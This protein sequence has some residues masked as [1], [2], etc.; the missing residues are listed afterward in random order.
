MNPNSESRS[1][2]HGAASGGGVRRTVALSLVGLGLG[3]AFEVLFYGHP[4]GLSFF[5]FC[6]LCLGAAAL[7]AGLERLR[8]AASAWLA[9][10]LALLFAASTFQRQEPLTVFLGVG[11]A[12][13]YLAVVVRV[14]RFGRL[15]RFGWIDLAVAFFWVPLEA[16]IRPWGTVGD[17]WR[18]TVRERGGR[19]VF[20]SVLRGLLLSLPLV[21]VF[22]A[23]LS[24]ADL[25][26]GDY[27]ADVLRWIDLERLA[28][29]TARAV[30]ILASGLYL[31]GALVAALRDPGDRRLVGEDPPLVRPFLGFTET[32]IV[33]T[34]VNLVFLLFVL[35]QFAYLFGGQ[36]NIHVAGYTYAEYARRG[37]GELV[38]VGFL[39]LGMIYA[40]AASTRFDGRGRRAGFF[41]LCAALVGLVGVMLFSAFQRLVLYEQAYGFSRLRTY[42]HVAIVWLAVGF[43]VFLGLLLLR[44]L[45]AVA[46]A[47]MI[48]ASGFGA[49]LAVLDVDAFIVDRNAARYE[50]TGDL[51]IAYLS[52]LSDDAVPALVRLA[53]RTEGDVRRDLL[54]ELSCRRNEIERTIGHLE[55]P[56][57]HASRR[58]ALSTL[59][60]LD[61]LL[62]V[63]PVYRDAGGYQGPRSPTYLVKTGGAFVPCAGI[64][65]D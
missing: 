58:R 59:A 43:V 2:E 55:W 39:A 27:V 51:D 46:L 23:L 20:F 6:A 13:F 5:V 49:T 42:T 15:F 63:Y 44:R 4:P 7:G 30:V 21:V 29:W 48:L 3:I 14:F 52:M 37:F 16:W 60:S 65:W 1:S 56:S 64:G 33:L 25:V 36:A 22:L 10:A 34:L 28:D 45:R 38:A 40:L 41:G 32:T 35:V 19:R 18:R 26:F 61:S 50:A 8:P 57:E 11:F 17:A 54:A 12:L 53:P 47:A 31:L 24:S 62:D 9:A